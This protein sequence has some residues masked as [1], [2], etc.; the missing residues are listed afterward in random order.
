M[1]YSETDFLQEV[2][3]TDYKYGFSTKLDADTA[4]KGL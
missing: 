1:S 3:D 2:A 4:P